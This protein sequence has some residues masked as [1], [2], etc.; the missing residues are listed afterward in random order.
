MTQPIFTPKE[1]GDFL[2][3]WLRSHCNSASLKSVSQEVG[4]KYSFFSPAKKLHLLEE[5]TF[6]YIS[7]AIHGVNEAL[8]DYETIQSIVD[9]FLEKMRSR[10]L[11]PM[12]SDDDNFQDRYSTRVGAYFELLNG[13]GDALG[14]AGDFLVGLFGT[15]EARLKFTAIKLAKDIMEAQASLQKVFRNI[16]VA[17]KQIL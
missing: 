7:L 9:A 6:L 3:D 16:D 4:Y 12:A 15:P 1:C 11:N 10:I 17:E 2:Y 5:L 8:T 13:G 14:V